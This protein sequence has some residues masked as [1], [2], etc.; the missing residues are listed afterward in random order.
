MVA[1][2]NSEGA[3]APVRIAR[4]RGA[5]RMAATAVAAALGCLLALAGSRHVAPL[6]WDEAATALRVATWPQ[7]EAKVTAASLDE[8]VVPGPA[9]MAAEWRLSL[10][11]EYRVDGRDFAG[12]QGSLTDRAPAGDRRLMALYRRAEFARI[13]GGPFAVSYD[14]AAPERAYAEASM[15]WARLL[16]GLAEGIA[17]FLA[18]GWC[19][20]LAFPDWPLRARR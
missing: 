18:A 7:V 19:F 20:A 4:R 6:P 11:Y 14:P 9:G 17:L 8:A 10:A 2:D 16:P 3:R 1:I 12:G 13:T 5:G 15:P